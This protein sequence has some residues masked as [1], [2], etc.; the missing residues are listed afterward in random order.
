MKTSKP[1]ARTHQ[2]HW[3]AGRYRRVPIRMAATP[4]SPITA[5]ITGTITGT[6]M[7]TTVTTV[8]RVM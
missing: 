6:V 1:A 2:G 4:A 7:Y 5:H 3:W 8:T